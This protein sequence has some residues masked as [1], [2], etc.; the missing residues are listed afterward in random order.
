MTTVILVNLGDGR[1][2]SGCDAQVSA[3]DVPMDSYGEKIFRWKDWVIGLCGV[4]QTRQEL[5]RRLDAL[6]E[7]EVGYTVDEIAGVMR[8]I[9]DWLNPAEGFSDIL[10]TSTA[11]NLAGDR[12]NPVY[13]VNHLGAIAVSPQPFWWACGSGAAYAIGYLYG[14]PPV[15]TGVKSLGVVGY[16]KGALA[17]ASRFDVWTGTRHIVK[18]W[19]VKNES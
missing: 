12:Y 1:V 5:I 13:L 11:L 14:K 10:L 2:V 19:E 6:P 15:G 8:G 17:C 18:M 16:V 4:A 3:G 7:R 9:Y